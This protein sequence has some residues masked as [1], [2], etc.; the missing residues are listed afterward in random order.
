MLRWTSNYRICIPGCHLKWRIHLVSLEVVNSNPF[1]SITKN[2][3]SNLSSSADLTHCFL[4]KPYGVKWLI[5]TYHQKFSLAFTCEYF[6]RKC[7]IILIKK[8]IVNKIT[9]ASPGINELIHHLLTCQ[10]EVLMIPSIEIQHFN[11]PSQNCITK[12]TRKKNKG[13]YKNR[14]YQNRMVY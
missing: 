5:S 13:W 10:Q 8:L 6:P 2:G 12:N 11:E 7:S 4:I 9:A 14:S 3:G 1:L